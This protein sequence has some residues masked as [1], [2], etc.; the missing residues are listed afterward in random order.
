MNSSKHM[1]NNSYFYPAIYILNFMII[2]NVP[3]V[4]VR[5]KITNTKK[6]NNYE[7]ITKNIPYSH[8]CYSDESK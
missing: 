3:V 8:A 6:M 2:F 5:T 1:S 7:M 4:P